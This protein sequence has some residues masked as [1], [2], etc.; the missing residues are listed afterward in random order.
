LGFDKDDSSIFDR[1]IDFI[2]E[3][4]LLGA[5][6]TLLTPLP[7]SRLRIRVEN[8]NRIAPSDWQAYTGWNALIKHKN[9]SAAELEAGLLKIYRNIYNQE[10]Y[11]QRAAYFRK[12]CE[13]LIK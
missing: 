11:R 5:Q 4:H 8:E 1:T 2:N 10:N 12:I 7:G 9:L 3:N 6:I 13:D